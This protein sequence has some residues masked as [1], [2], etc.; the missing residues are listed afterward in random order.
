VIVLIDPISVSIV[1]RAEL[2]WR[3]PIAPNGQWKSV[4][5]GFFDMAA[6]PA[7]RAPNDEQPEVISDEA[8]DP[9]IAALTSAVL[10][11]EKSERLP[12]SEA[13]GVSLHAA[14]I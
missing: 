13:V 8:T 14:R 12:C 1:V 5:L 10:D 6:V 4:S 9:S 11:A 7:I 2:I 3:D